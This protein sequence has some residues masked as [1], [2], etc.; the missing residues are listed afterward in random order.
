MCVTAVLGA[1]QIL[2]QLVEP[3]QRQSQAVTSGA[4]FDWRTAEA[5]LYCIRCAAEPSF[6]LHHNQVLAETILCSTVH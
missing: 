1:E 3:L 2:S 4:S 6:E 5:A